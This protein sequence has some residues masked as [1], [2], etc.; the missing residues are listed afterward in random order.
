MLEVDGF[1]ALVVLALWLWAIFDVITTDESLCRNLPKGVW[2]ML[3]IFLADIGALAWLILGR[4]Q[5]ASFYPGDTRPRPQRVTG[6]EDSP[7][8]DPR[9]DRRE[10][11]GVMATDRERKLREMREHYAALDAELDRRLEQKKLLGEAES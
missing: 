8:W 11:S 10:G 3:V 4:P 1:V 6:P 7:R 5:N 2:L 9:L